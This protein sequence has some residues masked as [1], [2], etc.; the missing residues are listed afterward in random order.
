MKSSRTPFLL[1]FLLALLF[2]PSSRAALSWE[3]L[4][5]RAQEMLAD[6]LRFSEGYWDESAGLLRSPAPGES[7]LHR[8]RESTWYALGLM[9]RNGPGDDA[10]ALRIVEKVL[11]YQ[12]DTPGQAWDG[13]YRRFLQ[14]PVPS[15]GAV[16]WRDYD[17][18]WRHFIGITFALILTEFEPR[19]P[20]G[21]APR[22][23]DSIRRGV[24]GEL[25]HGRAEPYHTNIK[26]MHGF[27]WSW[28]G[29]RLNRPEWVEGADRWARDVASAFAVHETFEE[30]NSPTYYG[31]DLYGLALWRRHGVTETMRRLGAEMEVGLWRDIGRFYHAGLR[32][33]AGP[34]DRAYGVDMRTHVSL[35]G[36]WMGLA[37]EKRLTPLPDPAG[38]MGHAHD[39]VCIPSYVALGVKVPP[40][41]LA[42][43]R[44]YQGDRQLERIITPD[45]RATAWITR[46]LMIGGE[47]THLTRDAGAGTNYGQF[48]PAAVHWRVGAGDVGWFA[49]VQSPRID[50]RA[51]PGRLV[52][53]TTAGDTRFRVGAPGLLPSMI[54]RGEWSLPNLAVRI[55]TDATA[56]DLEEGPGGSIEVVYR[57]ATRITAEILH[58]P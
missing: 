56:I 35:T 51:E 16:L 58:R 48:H 25:T 14:E 54:T 19:L 40:E 39:F 44:E 8:T 32:N 46:D 31:V 15:P 26:L 36:A 4:D 3:S 7:H 11:A 17:P 57:G 29:A 12:L 22:L 18:N 9:I 2:S 41:V 49:I 37:L 20:A 6:T 13:T 38:P 1:S 5:P 33:L 30:Y 42:G 50:A 43:F 45:R 53:N 47:I 21:L 27:L 34:Y 10:R 28:A 24:E 52:V 23:L 55:D